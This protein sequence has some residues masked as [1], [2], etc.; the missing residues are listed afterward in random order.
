MEKLPFQISAEKQGKTALVRIT[1][2]I[3]WD[4]D[5]LSLHSQ[6]KELNL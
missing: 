2:H 3:G 1:G 4:T 6:N 5:A